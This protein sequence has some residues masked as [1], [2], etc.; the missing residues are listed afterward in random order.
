MTMQQRGQAHR[1][2]RRATAAAH[3]Q[4]D[5]HPLLQRLLG[6]D[7]R[8]DQYAESLAALYRP[9]A[10]LERLVHESPQH[11]ESAFELSARV[12]RL[13]ADLREL[14]WSVPPIPQ[15]PPDPSEDR[16]TWWG[17]VYVLEGSRQGSAVIAR[18][19]QSSLCDTVPC[20]FFGQATISDDHK[21]LLATLERELESHAAL[22]QAVASAR[23]A[24]AAY[25]ADLDAFACGKRDV[26]MR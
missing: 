19:V 24:F 22:E 8:H 15:T 18:C 20:R 7:L 21:T 3:H 25:K 11:A 2:L 14:G 5:H 10:Q 4:L 6:P 23:A 1:R 9:H 16:A 13:E 26:E 12:E 17:R